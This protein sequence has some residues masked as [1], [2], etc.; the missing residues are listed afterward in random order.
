MASMTAAMALFSLNDAFVKAVAQDLPVAQIM[1]VRGVF[2]TLGVLA[3][4]AITR[5][6]GAFTG[7]F[8]RLVVMRSLAETAAIV[9]LIMAFA[10]IPIGDA[11]AVSQSVPL[12]LLPAAAIFLKERIPP[13]QWLLVVLGFAGVV[14]IAKPFTGGFEPAIGLA[15]VTAILFAFRDLTARKLAG[16]VSSTA[17]TLSTVGVVM[18]ASGA[19]ALLRG[20]SPMTWHQV[21]LL[22]V[23]GLLL[24]VGQAAV[25]LAFRL[26]P[27]S[28]AGPFNYTKTAFALVVGIVAFGEWP[29]LFSVAGGA[30]VVA[31]GLAIALGFGRRGA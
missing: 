6:P 4:L 31:S 15:V 29:D 28:D 21:G 17:V 3:Y 18:V 26:A 25:I 11:T 19:F 9:C 23:A 13:L 30:L 10:R 8:D 14:L 12:V 20:L 7:L 22:A 16:S 2:A 24:A 27:V 1:A 5:P